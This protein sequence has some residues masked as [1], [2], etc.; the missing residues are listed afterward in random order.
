MQINGIIDGATTLATYK[1]DL[2][3]KTIANPDNA[4]TL[5]NRSV[6]VDWST[7]PETIESC[8]ASYAIAYQKPSRE[9]IL[10]DVTC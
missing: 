3:D 4:Y 5:K 9:D 10:D 8:A 6:A 2:E 7:Y 1:V